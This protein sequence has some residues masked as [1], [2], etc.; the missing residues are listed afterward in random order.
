MDL[1]VAQLW[2][3][4]ERVTDTNAHSLCKRSIPEPYVLQ[5]RINTGLSLDL[6][7]QP[8]F[9]LIYRLYTTNSNLRCSKQLRRATMGN[10]DLTIKWPS[11]QL[12]H[13]RVQVALDLMAF[14]LKQPSPPCR[15]R[16]VV[17]HGATNYLSVPAKG[18]ESFTL[19][20]T[21]LSCCADKLRSGTWPKK[22]W[23]SMLCQ[24]LLCCWG[25]IWTLLTQTVIR[26]CSRTSAA[27]PDYWSSGFVV[28]T[29]GWRTLQ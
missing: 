9:A 10:H 3:C 6:I 20:I 24:S 19:N 23:F 17:N 11:W 8:H 14:A 1:N 13:S 15:L 18:E 27:V 26:D 2:L 28:S 16:S 22:Q 5:R 7:P 12:D 21:G 29:R 4:I 25:Y